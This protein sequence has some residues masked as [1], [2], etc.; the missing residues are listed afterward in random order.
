MGAVFG[1]QFKKSTKIGDLKSQ[2][3]YEKRLRDLLEFRE[4]K[5]SNGAGTVMSSKS[6]NSSGKGDKPRN[7]F[8]KDYKENFSKIKW[9]RKPKPDAS[10]EK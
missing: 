7:C 1:N 9:V 2:K 8:S 10:N 6:K 5:Q 4:I 3:P